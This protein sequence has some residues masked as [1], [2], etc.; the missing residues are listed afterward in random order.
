[1]VDIRKAKR[2]ESLQ[3]RHHVGFAASAADAVPPT[4]HSTALQQKICNAVAI[5]K[6][7]SEKLILPVLKQ[8]QIWKDQMFSVL[9]D[10]ACRFGWMAWNTVHIFSA[11]LVLNM[12]V[13]DSA[14]G[15]ASS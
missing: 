7:M 5:A 4:S 13:S 2:E 6:I 12:G 15:E 9:G 8:D 1:M 3:K 10:W 11:E 14:Y